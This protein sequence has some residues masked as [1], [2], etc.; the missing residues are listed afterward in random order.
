MSKSNTIGQKTVKGIVWNGSSNLFNV[1]LN[2]VITAVLA[3]LISPSDFGLMAIILI[4]INFAGIIADFGISA[5]V[6]QKQDISNKQLSSLFYL[7]IVIGIILTV[8]LFFSAFFIAGFFGKTELIH[9]LQVISFSFILISPGQIFRTYLQKHLEFKTIFKVDTASLIIYGI[10]SIW[11]AFHGMGIWSLVYGFIIRQAFNSF[12]LSIY[13]SLRLTYYF[14][15]ESIKNLL[16][17]SSFVFADRIFNYF[18]RNLD[19]IIVGKFLGVEAL[20]FYSLAYNLMLFPVSNIAQALMPVIFPAFSLVQ[21]NNEKIRYGYLKAVK[22]ISLVTF[23]LMTLLFLT[24]TEFISLAYGQKWLPAV[25]VI[26]VFCLVGAIQSIGTTVGTVLYA[27]GKS[28]ISFIWSIFA[29]I[30]FG[31]SFF[32]GVNWGIIGVAM[33]LTITSIILSPIIQHITNKLIDL[34]WSSFLK[35]FIVPILGSIFIIITDITTKFM[36]G[37]IYSILIT[38]II[39]ITAGALVYS[40]FIIFK[41]KHLLIELLGLLGINKKYDY[42]KNNNTL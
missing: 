14:N 28:N 5:A 1:A 8:L 13:S 34:S 40:V 42:N 6:I 24:T 18:F 33:A 31:I 19:N 25:P 11:F 23:P 27:K 20:G 35:Q 30:C 17:F 2:F 36:I 7:N 39:L 21:S 41:E 12:L 3:R 22:C 9:L 16:K 29:S 37:Q 15:F 26:Q 38:F 4:V 10:F 32:I